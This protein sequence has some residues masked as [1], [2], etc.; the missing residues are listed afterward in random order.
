MF[1]H[2]MLAFDSLSA[3]YA[4]LKIMTIEEREVLK[5]N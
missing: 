4:F 5:V 2:G 1:E 3:Q